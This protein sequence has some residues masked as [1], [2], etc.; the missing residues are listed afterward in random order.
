ME[1]VP[2]DRQ[3]RSD[4]SLTT[5]TP[6]R[7]IPRSTEL[8]VP[9]PRFSLSKLGNRPPSNTAPRADPGQPPCPQAD[10]I[11]RHARRPGMEQLRWARCPDQGQLH[12]LHPADVTLAR[13]R[14]YARA[15]CGQQIIAEGLTINSIA[16]GA[17]CMGC[18][19]AA[20]S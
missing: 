16:S 5:G 4:S 10:E 11:E 7:G 17:L 19:V 1:Q 6:P 13:V 15:L 20:G 18:V 2:H 14:G 9:D 8:R 3:A 12:L